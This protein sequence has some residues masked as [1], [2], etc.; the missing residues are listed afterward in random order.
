MGLRPNTVRDSR[1]SSHTPLPQDRQR[2]RTG[3]AA[4]MQS[5]SLFAKFIHFPIRSTPSPNG[6]MYP[7][8][9]WICENLSRPDVPSYKAPAY[10]SDTSRADSDG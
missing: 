9:Q 1:H 7:L 4:P 5:N 3:K 2:A 10:A 8:G 6:L